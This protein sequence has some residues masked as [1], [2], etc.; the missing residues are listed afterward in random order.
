MAA[1]V[2]TGANAQNLP[3]IRRAT[4]KPMVL[5]DPPRSMDDIA[6]RARK[7]LNHI[8]NNGMEDRYVTGYI[9][10]ALTKI[11][12]DTERLNQRIDTIERT[13]S[14]LS[15]NLSNPAANS[16][17]AWRNFRAREWQ[18]DL[19][20]AAAPNIRSNGTSSPGVPEIELREGREVIVKVE[21]NREQ[22]RGLTPKDLVERAE[23]Q[24]TTNAR[25]KN[26][27]VLA[28]QASFVAA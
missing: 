21:P 20:K 5:A 9:R 1:V 13:T 14:T 28:G 4:P 27:G 17:A 23:R 6:E 18:R 19:A 8:E 3:P 15:T 2:A 10:A 24:R 16:A 7:V 26:S 22:I 12:I 11:N 25:Q